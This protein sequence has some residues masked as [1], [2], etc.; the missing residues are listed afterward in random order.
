MFKILDEVCKPLIKTQYSAG[1]D[2]CS[3][4][5]M[6]IGAGDIKI[7]PLGIKIDLDWFKDGFYKNNDFDKYSYDLFLRSHYFKIA[8][9]SSLSAKKGLIIA[10]GE[11]IVDMDYKGEMGLIVH[12]PINM[13]SV[14]NDDYS[15]DI[16]IKKGDRVAQII[17]M[18][19]R[20]YLIPD[21]YKSD[22]TRV[23]GFGSTK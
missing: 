4:E 8:I 22:N 1:A 3:R 10:N 15:E 13:F 2:L 12:N 9:R 14:L 6:S 11:G 5:D 20:N 21:K 17:L 16:K 18:E 19:H 23:G 7:I